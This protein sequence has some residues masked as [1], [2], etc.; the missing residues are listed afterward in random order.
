MFAGHDQEL[1][2]LLQGCDSLDA[3]RLRDAAEECRLSGRPLA[4]ILVEQGVLSQPALLGLVAERLGF[5]CV[6]QPPARLRTKGLESLPAGLA[7]RLGVVPLD[8]RTVLAID[9][10]TRGLA[11]DLAFA[12]G[13]E[14][15]VAVADPEWVQ[16]LLTQHYGA[17]IGTNGDEGA[18]TGHAAISPQSAAELQTMAA[19]QPV[20]RFVDRVLGQAVRDKA[21]DIHF[22]PFE[23]EFKVRCRIDGALYEMPSPPKA[24]A[25]PVA[26][27]LKVLANLDIA[28]RRLPQDGRIRFALSGRTVDLRVSTLPTQFGESVVLRVL[29]QSAVRL[30]LAQLTMPASIESAVRAVIR[31]PSGIFVVTGPTGSGK[32]TTLYSCLREIS[33]PD[34]KILS[35]E[36]PV[37]YELE[38]VMQVP[39]NPAA[40]LTFARALRSFLRQDPDIVMVGEIRDLETAQIAM[41][42]SLTGHLVLTTLHTNDAPAAMTRLV[43]MGV[44]PFL[45]ASTLEAVLAQRLVRR[46]CPDCR[47]PFEPPGRTLPS[48]GIH[49]ESLA[50]GKIH[51]ARGCPRCQRTGYCGRMG[52]FELLPLDAPLREL[53]AAGATLAQ[54]RQAAADAG[55]KSLREAARSALLAGDTSLEEVAPYL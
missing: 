31:R 46:L 14:V 53:V 45:I 37:E 15:R 4:T 26:S 44:E 29:D 49:P 30:D 23:D 36:D 13:R 41:Q 35:V 43:D 17:A 32:T 12:L 33:N 20:V 8:E 10:F 24:L 38:G 55:M 9:P 28:E 48:I 34:V 51:R 40:D 54:L 1:L 22:E 27:R 52:L 6:M 47:E 16:M 39:V 25:L 18:G 2:T 50:E 11:D 7:R 42:A 21:S 19:Q 5:A 3:H